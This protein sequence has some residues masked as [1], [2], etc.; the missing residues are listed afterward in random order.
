M[1]IGTWGH[2]VTGFDITKPDKPVIDKDPNSVLDYTEDWTQWLL[3]ASGGDVD[4][5]DTISTVEILLNDSDLSLDRTTVISQ[6]GTKVTAWL[7]GNGF[8]GK[9]GITFRITTVAGRIDDRTLYFKA[10]ER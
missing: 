7:D 9:V 3:D 6:D 2:I 5:L 8:T 1:K 10:V 4:N